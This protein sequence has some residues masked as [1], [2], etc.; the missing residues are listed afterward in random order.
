MPVPSLDYTE[1]AATLSSLT[2]ERTYGSTI[3]S[4][5]MDR[6][7][8]D[9]LY[10]ERQNAML[11]EHAMTNGTHVIGQFLGSVVYNIISELLV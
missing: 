9:L 8:P 7:A 6:S 3:F 11:C 5:L 4:R 1:T 2:V 10:S